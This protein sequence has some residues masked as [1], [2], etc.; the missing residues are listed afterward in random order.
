LHRATVY[1]RIRRIEQ[2]AGVDFADGEQR[3]ALHLG[4]KLARL[5][6]LW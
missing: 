6:G 3:L 1:Q 2:V 4:I 5:L